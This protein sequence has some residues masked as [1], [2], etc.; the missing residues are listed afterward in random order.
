M[1]DL[2]QFRMFDMFTSVIDKEVK[3]VILDKF[4]S[5]SQI[6]IVVATITFGLGIDCP[7]VRQ[8]VHMGTA[9]DKESYVQEVGRAGRDGFPALTTTVYL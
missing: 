1:P 9:D 5:A 4:T 3:E 2:P 6:R 7:D 8:V